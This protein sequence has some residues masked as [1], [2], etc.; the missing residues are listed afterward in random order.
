MEKDPIPSNRE[1]EVPRP[2]E[3]TFFDGLTEDRLARGLDDFAND[4]PADSLDDHRGKESCHLDEDLDDDLGGEP[5]EPRDECR[6]QRS[7]PDAGEF[8]DDQYDPPDYDAAG[9][10]LDQRE[11]LAAAFDHLPLFE[12]T[13]PFRTN[14]GHPRKVRA[15][16]RDFGVNHVRL[17]RH[18]RSQVGRSFDDVYSQLCRA[19]DQRPFFRRELD[20]T[21]ASLVDTGVRLVDG[22][23]FD[24]MGRYPISSGLWVHPDT[25]KL[26][27][28]PRAPRIYYKP[29]PRFEQLDIDEST[30]LVRVKGIWYVVA[31][32]P[33]PE[34]VTYR[35]HS[36]ERYAPKRYDI[37]L[38]EE[39][40]YSYSN[41]EFDQSACKLEWGRE[42]YADSKQAA[43]KRLIRRCVKRSAQA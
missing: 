39:V 1:T 27:L 28:Q 23:P 41:A 43:G 31:F 32:K 30:K 5:E 19:S 26:M 10:M 20:G 33:L 24:S 22:E 11:A 14:R 37:V 40:C 34:W 15:S 16:R 3:H 7:E 35:C 38:C 13:S 12:S 42:I 6:S 36:P 21:I 17:H 2:Y 29:K 25:G 8:E 18:L 9:A 4:E